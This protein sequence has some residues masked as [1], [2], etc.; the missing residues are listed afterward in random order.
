M[1][2]SRDTK[3][4]HCPCQDGFI[5]AVPRCVNLS[6][7]A[8]MLTRRMDSGWVNVLS[9]LSRANRAKGSP[10]SVAFCDA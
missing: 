4:Q 3:L 8:T 1:Y 6:C 7:I 2:V 10:F 5:V 9:E